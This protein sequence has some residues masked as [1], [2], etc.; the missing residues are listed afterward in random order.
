MTKCPS[1]PHL[2]QSKVRATQSWLINLAD[3]LYTAS[4]VSINSMASGS[5]KRTAIYAAADGPS[6]GSKSPEII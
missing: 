5:D 2:S 3:T 1:W 6:P 4:I